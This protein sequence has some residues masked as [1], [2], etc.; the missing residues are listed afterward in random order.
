MLVISEILSDDLLV[1]L[2][3]IGCIAL[4]EV[5]NDAEL[6]ATFVLTLTLSADASSQSVAFRVCS[7]RSSRAHAQGRSST[8]ASSCSTS[9]DNCDRPPERQ[10]AIPGRVQVLQAAE[11]DHD[12][13][14]RVLQVGLDA[15]RRPDGRGH[16]R[17]DNPL[18][19]PDR[20]RRPTKRMGPRPWQTSNGKRSDRVP[21]RTWKPA[22]FNQQC[23]CVPKSGVETTFGAR[24]KTVIS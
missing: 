22:M 14:H 5:R 7:R 20:V 13:Q 23:Y 24:R 19:P 3:G 8:L 6:N 17:Q 9:W 11:P 16:D 4:I 1:E 18:R 21:H 2:A 15:R 12:D 10:A